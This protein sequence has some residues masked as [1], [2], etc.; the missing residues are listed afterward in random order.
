MGG[1][2]HTILLYRSNPIAQGVGGMPSDM[3]V[4]KMPYILSNLTNTDFTRVFEIVGQNSAQ[5][6]FELKMGKSLP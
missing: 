3:E 1:I 5:T 4:G 6:N 2:I